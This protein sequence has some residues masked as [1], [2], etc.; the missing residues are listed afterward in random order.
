MRVALCGW[1]VGTPAFACT[2]ADEP[3][4]AGSGVS[5][6]GTG[7][8]GTAGALAPVGSPGSGR[9]TSA[10][11]SSQL[12]A[13]ILISQ[14]PAAGEQH[15]CV[16]VE[17][18]NTQP[19][20]VNEIHA[21]LSTGS[22]H[23]IV[24]RRSSTTEVQTNA[25]TCAPTMAGDDTRLLIAQQRETRVT[26]PSGV[27]YKL[28]AHQRIFLQ[29]HYINLSTKPEDVQG[30]VE[31][32]LANKAAGMPIE[33]KSVFA[34]ALSINLP[35][36]SPGS[37]SSFQ[38][39][40][41]SAATGTTRHVFA[42]TSHTHSLGVRATI[43]RVASANAPPTQPIHES[44]NWSEPPL[45]LFDPPLD[46]SASGTDGLR[47]ICNY[48]NDTDHAVMFGTAFED[49]MCFMWMYFYDE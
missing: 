40:G 18:P 46:F 43:E 44:L 22:H 27:A 39:P 35:A 21:T 41:K 48:M 15:T 17:L 42:L 20:W 30:A 3:S 23:L 7:S 38:V 26:L 14:V 8:A 31:L 36:H 16:I 1:I 37:A 33:A 2:S 19:V 10:G 49:E 6:T 12:T 11:D 5:G 24:D 29:L 13:A 25:E 28:D 4:A 34:G 32:K 47:L 9:G 45:T